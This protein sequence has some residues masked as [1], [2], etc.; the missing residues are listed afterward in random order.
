MTMLF[1]HDI[2]MYYETM[3][4]CNILFLD[5]FPALIFR[6]LS[7]YMYYVKRVEENNA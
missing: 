7:K 3:I 6:L 5:E 4:S 2:A 1:I